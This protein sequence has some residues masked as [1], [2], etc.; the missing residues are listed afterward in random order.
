MNITDYKRL[1]LKHDW[2]YGMSDDPRSYERGLEEER[3]LK[4]LAEGKKTY[5]NA[6]KTEEKKHRTDNSVHSIRS[7]DRRNVNVSDNNDRKA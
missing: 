1:L 5:Q 3:V 6:Y 7:V 2:H 4:K